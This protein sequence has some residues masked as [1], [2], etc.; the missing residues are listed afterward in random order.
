MTLLW[1]TPEKKLIDIYFEAFRTYFRLKK[2]YLGP[3]AMGIRVK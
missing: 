2:G 3:Y 1:K